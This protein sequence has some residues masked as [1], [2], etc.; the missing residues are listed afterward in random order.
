MTDW[1]HRCMILPDS[2]RATIKALAASFDPSTEAMWNTPLNAT[3]DINDPPTHWVSSG[4]ISAGFAAVLP[5]SHYVEG[6]LDEQGFPTLVW[7]TEPY[8]AQ[9][10]VDLAEQFGVDPLPTVE[11]ISALMSLCDVSDQ[12]GLVALDRLGLKLIN[13]PMDSA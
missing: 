4:F 9:G 8:D 7:V 13:P 6:P 3:G 12:E 5:F 10:F 1:T 2:I 11:Q